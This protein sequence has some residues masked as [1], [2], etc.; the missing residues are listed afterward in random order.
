M[1][2]SFPIQFGITVGIEGGAPSPKHDIRLG[3]GMVGRTG[4]EFFTTSSA[5]RYRTRSSSGPGHEMRRL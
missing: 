2:R 1:R 4:A 5:E 3:D